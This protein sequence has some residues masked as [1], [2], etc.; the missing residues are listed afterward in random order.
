MGTQFKNKIKF[1]KE[2]TM[3]IL[4]IFKDTSTN[5]VQIC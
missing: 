3:D 1:K 2:Y 5:I 4:V